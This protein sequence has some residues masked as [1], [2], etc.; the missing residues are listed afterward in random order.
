VR[1]SI[2]TVVAILLI[3]GL[4]VIPLSDAVRI[5]LAAVVGWWAS[6]VFNTP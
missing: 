2:A 5:S 4:M 6:Y 3:C 1:Q